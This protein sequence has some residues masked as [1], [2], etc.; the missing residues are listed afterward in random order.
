MLEQ[1]YGTLPSGESLLA[2]EENQLQGHRQRGLPHVGAVVDAQRY[3]LCNK[4]ISWH[5]S[6][7][8]PIRRFAMV[9]LG[10]HLSCGVP[11]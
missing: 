1:I 2:I 5:A 10:D 4:T 8:S 9:R 7:V 6:V 11:L 3:I